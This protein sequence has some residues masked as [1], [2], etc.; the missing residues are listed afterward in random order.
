VP[1]VWA[2]VSQNNGVFK[3]IEERPDILAFKRFLATI[4]ARADRQTTASLLR[5]RYNTQ[6]ISRRRAGWWAQW[7]ARGSHVSQARKIPSNPSGYSASGDTS[8]DFRSSIAHCTA[9]SRD[10]RVAS[11]AGSKRRL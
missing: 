1:P 5:G 8:I 7:W 11:S 2:V 4:D 10:V 3:K 6:E 9:S